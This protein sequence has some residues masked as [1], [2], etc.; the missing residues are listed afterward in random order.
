MSIQNY[1]KILIV[2][3]S[4]RGKTT[5][6]KKLSRKLDIKYYELDNIFWIKKYTERRTDQEQISLVNKLIAKENMW[7]IEGTTRHMIEPCLSASDIIIHLTFKSIIEQWLYIIKRNIRSGTTLI[8]T[9]E[10]CKHVYQK[11]FGYGRNSTKRTV[12][13]LLRPYISK[14]VELRSWKEIEGFLKDI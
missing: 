11:R 9:I 14:T 8:E 3:D 7:I 2:G 6:A 4:G 1:N 5:L 10:L 13:E 12:R